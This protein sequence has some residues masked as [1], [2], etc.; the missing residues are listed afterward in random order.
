MANTEAFQKIQC[1]AAEFKEAHVLLAMAKAR[2]PHNEGK[3][4]S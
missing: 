2:Y 3:T 4:L 1:E